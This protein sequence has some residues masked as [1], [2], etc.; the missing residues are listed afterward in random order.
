MALREPSSQPAIRV[1]MMP[2]D[3]NPQGTIF[4]GVLLSLM[5]QA[6]AVEAARQAPQNRYVTVAFD[7]VEFHQPVHVGDVVSIWASATKVGR[8]SI[9]IHV[10]VQAQSRGQTTQ[11]TVTQGDVVMVAIDEAGKPVAVFGEGNR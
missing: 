11:T 7:R 9:T 2:R 1:V 10:E 5:D 6:A 3:V 4:G 8:T